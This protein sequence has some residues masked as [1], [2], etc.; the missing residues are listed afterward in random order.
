M[1]AGG[2]TGQFQF[3]LLVSLKII[4]QLENGNYILCSENHQE[5]NVKKKIVCFV[6]K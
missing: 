2:G 4:F 1:G 5:G 3:I 6:R